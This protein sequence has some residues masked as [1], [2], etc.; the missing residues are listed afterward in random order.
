M[1][2][3]KICSWVEV[4]GGGGAGE[5]LA[6]WTKTNGGS[7]AWFSKSNAQRID[8]SVVTK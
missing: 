7:P 4:G 5:G 3:S 8:D 1:W 6:V 2:F